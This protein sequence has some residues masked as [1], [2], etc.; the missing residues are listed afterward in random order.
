MR[1]LISF[2]AV[3]AVAILASAQNTPPA[4]SPT[5]DAL[6]ILRHVTQKYADA[7]SLHLEATQELSHNTELSRSWNKMILSVTVAPENRYRYEGR[8]PLGAA[9]L[10]SD[11]KTIW[12]YH[13]G[14]N[15]FTE[16]PALPDKAMPMLP[17]EDA[18]RMAKGL[19][20]A[21][22]LLAERL[23]SAEL[24]AEETLA[25]DGRQYHCIRIHYRPTDLKKRDMPEPEDVR[26]ESTD[27]GTYWIDKDRMVIIKI[28]RHMNSTTTRRGSTEPVASHD[29]VL[30]VFT[31]VELNSSVPDSFFVFNSPAQAKLVEEFPSQKRYE[32]QQRALA[33]AEENLNAQLIGSPAPMVDLKSEDGKV[34]SLSSYRG[35]PVLIDVWAT[36]CGPCVAMIPELKKLSA[37]LNAHGV[38]F[39]SVDVGDDAGAAARL[40]KEHHVPWPN[41]HD[42]GD[43]MRSAFHA[44]SAVPWQVFID[45]DGKLAFYHFGEDLA[46]LQAEIAALGPKYS[47]I[48]VPNTEK[49]R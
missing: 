34:I 17:G 4:P 12:T 19:P 10:V 37:D 28:E 9:L 5:P 41:L 38:A 14:E 27:E 48:A 8:G 22:G 13:Y 47:S 21:L 1:A 32:L 40:L 30:Q 29:E 33:A 2:I 25:V 31:S 15:L 39:L 7:K 3:A 35:K 16:K 46:S 36:W 26:R 11:G 44:S 23:N 49:P 20:H 24:L 43:A 18:M 42:S 6:Q 45:S